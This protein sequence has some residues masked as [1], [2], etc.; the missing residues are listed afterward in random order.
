VLSEFNA[1]KAAHDAKVAI[2]AHAE[3]NDK[4]GSNAHTTNTDPEMMK[5]EIMVNHFSDK[6][7]H[8]KAVLAD[9]A[10]AISTHT[11]AS[12]AIEPNRT[13]PT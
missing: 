2:A 8:A 1:L 13:L 9:V 7:P 3:Y 11:A 10:A 12:K 6:M 4:A 5:Y